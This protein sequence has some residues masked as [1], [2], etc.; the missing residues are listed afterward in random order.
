MNIKSILSLT[1]ALL[2]GAASLQGQDLAGAIAP[3]RIGI[4]LT[5]GANSNLNVSAQPGMLTSYGAQAMS[6]DWTDK[7]LA[8]GMEGSLIFS[9]HWKLDLGGSFSYWNNPPYAMVP[10]TMTGAYEVGEIPTYEAV[11]MQH[12]MNWHAY[13]AGS[14]YFRIL[15][16]P[17]LRPYAGIRFQ[18]SY[19]SASLREDSENALGASVAEGYSGSVGALVGVDYYLT[20]N[21]FVG[22]SV[23]PFRYTYGVVQY[24]PQEGLSNLGADTHYMGAFAAPQLKIG[25]VF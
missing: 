5:A 10:G 18:A 25:F 12:K 24:R 11:D 20:R 22:A 2:F 6:V 21:F 15:L 17:A 16:V 9:D 7:A 19:A 3:V 4:A 14:Y 1:V 8:F 13:I 23:E